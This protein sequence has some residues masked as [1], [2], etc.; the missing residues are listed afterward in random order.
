M[1]LHQIAFQKK[2]WFLDCLKH[3]MLERETLDQC[4]YLRNCKLTLP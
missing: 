3:E 1:R 4:Q 2:L